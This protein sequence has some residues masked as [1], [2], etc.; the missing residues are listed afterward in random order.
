LTSY[1]GGIDR[2]VNS[3]MI[4]NKSDLDI[5]GDKPPPPPGGAAILSADATIS[6]SSSRKSVSIPATSFNVEHFVKEAADIPVELTEE[7]FDR[8]LRHQ[9]QKFVKSVGQYSNIQAFLY[10][11]GLVLPR[12]STDDPSHYD[13]LCGIYNAKAQEFRRQLAGDGLTLRKGAFDLIRDLKEEGI[14]IGLTSFSK[15]LSNAMDATRLV[16]WFDAILDG[17][18]AERLGLKG[19]P[20]IDYFNHITEQLNSDPKRTVL[21]INDLLGFDPVELKHF[22]LV[23][24]PCDAELSLQGDFDH[25]A[26]SPLQKA[27]GADKCYESLEGVTAEVIDQWVEVMEKELGVNKSDNPFLPRVAQYRK[28]VSADSSRNFPLKNVQ[29][30]EGELNAGTGGGEFQECKCPE[31]SAPSTPKLC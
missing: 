19:K 27:A 4:F 29:N 2:E 12:G 11:R 6:R 17:A 5:L 28:I 18:S 16:G 21:F 8:Y 1:R 30:P 14:A 13:T 23:C 10:S 3:S 24:A 9:H 15:S 22:K 26:V 25:V 20:T 7:D 31:E